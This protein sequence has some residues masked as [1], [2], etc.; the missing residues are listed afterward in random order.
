MQLGV[1]HALL[2]NGGT[3]PDYLVGVSAGAVNAAAVAE[4]LQAVPEGGTREDF[5]KM[6]AEE[7]LPFQVD[8]L[9]NFIQTYIELP[10]TVADSLL[11]DSLEIQAREPLQPLELP[12]HFDLERDARETANE[13]KAGLLGLF[14]DLLAIQLTVGTATRI[15][16][17]ILGRIAAVEEGGPVKRWW[18]TVKNESGVVGIFWTRA[19]ETAPLIAN[20]CVAYIVGPN[21]GVLRGATAILKNRSF[22][23]EATAERLITRANVF[24]HTARPLRFSA[25]LFLILH[26]YFLGTLAWALSVPLRFVVACAGLF[27]RQGPPRRFL[28]LRAAFRN[29]G[30]WFGVA[31]QPPLR[32]VLRYYGLA[33]GLANTDAFKQIFVNCFD[34]RYYGR[35]ELTNILNRALDHNNR[36]ASSTDLY[37]KRLSAYKQ[38]KPP[39]R[40]A[41]VAADVRTG[42]LC[43]LPEQVPVVDALLAAT[44]KVPFFPAVRIDK[45]RESIRAEAADH[46]KKK[47]E[48]D[49]IDREEKWQ[50]AR[51]ETEQALKKG[52]PREE[53][54]SDEREEY[55]IDERGDVNGDEGEGGTWYIDGANIS[56]EAIGPLLE[57]L[58]NL[59]EKE[60][61]D[62]TAVDVY[63]V[64]SLPIS[65]P[66]LPTEQSFDGGLLDVVPRALQLKRFRD[67]TVE[68]QLTALYSKVLPQDRA[69]WPLAEDGKSPTK[70][71]KPFINA[72]IFP[73]E[74]KAPVEIQKRLLEGERAGFKDLVYQTIADGCRASMEGMLP[75]LVNDKAAANGE[76]LCETVVAARIAGRPRLPGR[77][78]AVGPGLSEICAQCALSRKKDE[79]RPGKVTLQGA[80]DRTDWPEWPLDGEK[81]PVTMT[82]SP[83][84]P[85]ASDWPEWP[86]GDKTPV[87]PPQPTP[88]IDLGTW[89]SA[90][91]A[92]EGTKRP[93]VSLLFGGGVFRGVFHV[94]V[95][96]ALNEVG[97]YPDIVAGSSVGSIVA[98]MVAQVFSNPVAQHREI[99]HLAATF[100][101]ID[102]LVLTDRLADFIRRLTLH[103][104]DTK[105]SL[106]DLDHLFRRYDDESAA[107]FNRRS[108]IVSAGLE[109]LTHISPFE[110]IEL[111]RDLRTDQFRGFL[112]ALRDDVQ[113]FLNHGG[114]GQEILGSEPLSLLINNHVL[115]GRR[116]DDP[117]RDDLFESFRDCGIYFLA[118]ATNLEKGE[119]EILGSDELASSRAPSLL[120]GLLASSAFPAIFRPRHSWEIF[121]ETSEMHHYIDGGVMDNLPLDAVARFLDRASHA[122][123]GAI[124]RRPKIGNQEVPHLIFTASLEVDP[125]IQCDADELVGDCVQLWKRAKTL[126]YNQKINAFATTQ[127]DLRAIWNARRDD[128]DKPEEPLDLHV[129]NVKPKWLCDTFG[130]HPMLGFRRKKQAQSIAH[131]CASTFATIYQTTVATDGHKPWLD[132]WGIR[133]RV[134]FDEK[135]FAFFDRE[136]IETSPP[137][138]ENTI[139]LR[140]VP[141]KPDGTPKDVDGMC[142]FRT[143]SKCPFAPDELDR[144]GVMP[145]KRDEISQIYALC[146]AASTHRARRSEAAS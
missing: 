28:K 22:R 135:S 90:R 87:P 99:A 96:N 39:I 53:Y 110:L 51:V 77:K 124:A 104:A 83:P 45:G 50:E 20:L 58:R 144:A 80:A 138:M 127:C 108:R 30:R 117:T 129:M 17:K 69:C 116:A 27:A 121:R 97:L 84:P 141:K 31:F 66:Q 128:K 55:A 76:V 63:R 73:L 67:A 93:L 118:T 81:T 68:Q 79:P 35:A 61:A 82:A 7:R 95:M 86:L 131:G 126:K 140:P 115:N 133:Q 33:D 75:S 2:V 145:Q 19:R 101:S 15:A 5:E 52:Q 111:A 65:K 60:L 26:A 71:G 42:K 106:S 78:V 29:V 112:K 18:K 64:S 9:R 10:A 119:L 49:N 43:V 74:L 48:A 24:Q 44:A 146:G 6:S 38:N 109:R 47:D 36:A 120:Y 59:P 16:R 72:R 92:I 21:R 98:A 12:I 13:A 137:R 41:P 125:T 134:D 123:S 100:L 122:M 94:G 103:A 4:I 136:G 85:T 132:S 8:K 142:W 57:Y 70:Y 91:A 23:V 56:N 34:R 113:D 3:A 37:R 143:G 46:Q 107:S 88:P 1:A 40:V 25:K 14:N 102:R 89:P 32:R 139:E 54:K 130:F 11:P 62:A 114:V 105:F